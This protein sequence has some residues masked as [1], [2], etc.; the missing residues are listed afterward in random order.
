MDENQRILED[1]RASWHEEAYATALKE[2][3]ERKLQGTERDD[4]IK[5]RKA[6]RYAEL[7][8]LGMENLTP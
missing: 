4:F 6:E 8:K 5:T 2:A 7:E 1:C 3:D